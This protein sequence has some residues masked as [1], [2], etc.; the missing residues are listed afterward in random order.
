MR[1]VGWQEADWLLKSHKKKSF[2]LE[3][4]SQNM[5]VAFDKLRQ[6]LMRNVASS[7]NKSLHDNTT[8]RVSNPSDSANGNEFDPSGSGCAKYQVYCVSGSSACSGRPGAEER[9][10]ER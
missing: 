4:T 6:R 10:T 3:E 2:K 7:I 5:A 8:T 9:Q 1:L